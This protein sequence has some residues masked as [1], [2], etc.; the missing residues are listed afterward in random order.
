[1]NKYKVKMYESLDDMRE[2]YLT[3][4]YIVLSK[5]EL[6]DEEIKKVCFE[7]YKHHFDYNDSVENNFVWYIE[8][9]SQDENIEVIDLRK[10][11]TNA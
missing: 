2:N 1:M 5:T 7:R 8:D 6:P 11:Q 3:D 9:M 10:E 4:K